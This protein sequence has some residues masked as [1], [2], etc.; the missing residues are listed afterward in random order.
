MRATTTAMLGAVCE[1]LSEM[2]E[3]QSHSLHDAS[4]PY[5]THEDYDRL[6]ELE[7]RV[8][9]LRT[10]AACPDFIAATTSLL[11][12]ETSRCHE[13]TKAIRTL[14]DSWQEAERR[15]ESAIRGLAERLSLE[16][17]VCARAAPR[18]SLPEAFTKLVPSLRVGHLPTSR[19]A[20]SALESFKADAGRLDSAITAA[21]SALDDLSQAGRDV[22][23]QCRA[24]I[25]PIRDRVVARRVL[26]ASGDRDPEAKTDLGTLGA[27]GKQYA[28]LA[29]TTP[30]RLS[31]FECD[32]ALSLYLN[33]AEDVAS[34]AISLRE[35]RRISQTY[36]DFMA[37]IRA[38]DDAISEAMSLE[39]RCRERIAAAK[40][41]HEVAAREVNA[42]RLDAMA[43]AARSPLIKGKDL[44]ARARQL[45]SIGDIALAQH[46]AATAVRESDGLLSGSDVTSAI[47]EQQMHA[48]AVCRSFV[49]V[50]EECTRQSS[51][52]RRTWHELFPFID[53]YAPLRSHLEGFFDHQKDLRWGPGSTLSR[54]FVEM[55]RKCRPWC[56]VAG[57]K[58][59]LRSWALL[60]D[61]MLRCKP[62]DVRPAFAFL[63]ALC[64]MAHAHDGLSADEASLIGDIAR[65][66]G[67]RADANNFSALLEQWRGLPRD[68]RTLEAVAQAIID[69]DV[70]TDA[71]T[72][73]GLMEAL[74]RVAQADD[75][76]AP[77]EIAVYQGFVTTLTRRMH[78]EF[79]E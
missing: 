69:V 19:N 46:L 20:L 56:E 25:P 60:H 54:S 76:L 61:R 15:H 52:W 18:H 79:S 62:R 2:L 78:P 49:A 36:E 57:F 35:S 37:A 75:K 14:I 70:I 28:F 26:V 41:F 43:A 12:D 74:R 9:E 24:T 55:V 72:L 53:S 6:R 40:E 77:D 31:H 1:M 7:D 5:L 27:Q 4:N 34:S 17:Y 65:E 16:L 13:C 42:A 10:K 21:Q 29:F 66:Q 38:V 22:V 30:P 71:T 45:A 47:A 48:S 8:R 73:E 32:S 39:D 58:P 59:T 50:E 33:V 67:I 3:Q 64:A 63:N 23:E 51:S 44:L 68:Q 11:A